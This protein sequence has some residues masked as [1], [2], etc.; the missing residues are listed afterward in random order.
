MFARRKMIGLKKNLHWE[1]NCW[2]GEYKQTM[3]GHTHAHTHSTH[4]H[5][6]TLTPHAHTHSH[7]HTHTHIYTLQDIQYDPED[8]DDFSTPEDE[9]GKAVLAAIQEEKRKR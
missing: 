7:T 6:H 5:T 3:H 2:L 4:T 8:L 9:K 1:W